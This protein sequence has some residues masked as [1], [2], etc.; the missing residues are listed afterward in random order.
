[1]G[2][3]GKPYGFYLPPPD[4]F[5][6][7]LQ[8]LNVSIVS[9]ATCRTVFPGRITDNMVCA[10]GTE[11]ADACQVS[12]C[13]QCVVTQGRTFGTEQGGW[14]ADRGGQKGEAQDKAGRARRWRS[15]R[16]GG[17]WK[18]EGGNREGKMGG[19]PGEGEEEKTRE[20]QRWQG[21]GT[22]VCNQLSL[23]IPSSN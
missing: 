18:T 3:F 10:I 20:G 13:R 4:P 21:L 15:E 9:S 14:G 7:L 23:P 2:N 1:M 22:E 16:R 19:A 17:W 5:P 6:D 12:E 11:G 8:C